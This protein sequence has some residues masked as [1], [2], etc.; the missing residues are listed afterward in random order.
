MRSILITAPI[1]IT[2]AAFATSAA[3]QQLP[4]P[5]SGGCPPGFRES[6][7]YCVAGED[8]WTLAIPRAPNQ[9]CRVGWVGHGAY[10]SRKADRR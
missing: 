9:G 8:T 5:K 3:A 1:L 2:G 10:R 7:A 4:L 6:G